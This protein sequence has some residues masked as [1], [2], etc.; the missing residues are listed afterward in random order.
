[1]FK[2]FREP[3]RKTFKKPHIKP[4]TI[5]VSQLLSKV[6]KSLYIKPII[7]VFQFLFKL[8]KSFRM[9]LIITIIQSLIMKI[10]ITSISF[11]VFKFIITLKV[12]VENARH[13]IKNEFINEKKKSRNN[14]NITLM[15]E[16]NSQS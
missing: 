6:F 16:S 3:L 1:M 2:V 12:F 13:I 10:I 11:C 8:F 15:S 5:V 4:I 7:T 9:K 14:S